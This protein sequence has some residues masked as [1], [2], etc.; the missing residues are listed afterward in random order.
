MD[1]KELYIA[2]GERLREQRV[3]SGLTQEKLAGRLGMSL[4]YYGRIERGLSG[5]SL[6]KLIMAS[7]ELETDPTYL[8]TGEERINMSFD[9]VVEQ[10]PKEKQNDMYQILHYALKLIK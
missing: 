3:K 1:K 9:V 5:L 4:T 6:E 8:L 7:K 2:M 10:C